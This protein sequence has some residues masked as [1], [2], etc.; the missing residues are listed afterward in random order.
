MTSFFAARDA[1]CQMLAEREV[2]IVAEVIPEQ[3]SPGGRR[4][5]TVRITA[6]DDFPAVYVI[7]ER[8]WVEVSDERLTDPL[9][10][11]AWMRKVADEIEKAVQ[12]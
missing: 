2:A 11:A 6:G 8:D 4:P 7:P 3:P 1:A 5:E 12:S 10:V 9:A